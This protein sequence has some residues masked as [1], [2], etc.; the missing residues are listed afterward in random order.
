VV[1]TPGIVATVGFA[2]GLAVAV[3]VAT[4]DWLGA[5]GSVICAVARGVS[6]GLSTGDWLGAAGSVN[7]A[8]ARGVAVGLPRLGLG[9]TTM[10]SGSP[11]AS[12]GESM[13]KLPDPVASSAVGTS[14]SEV[15]G[16]ADGAEVGMLVGS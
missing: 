4:G 1:G 2:V 7:C 6:V 11:A 13:A 16:P 10:T 9:G 15:L 5:P 14:D 12:V 8:A 3:I